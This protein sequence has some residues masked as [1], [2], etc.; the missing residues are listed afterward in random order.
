VANGAQKEI[1]CRYCGSP[2][3]GDE[4][5]GRNVF[6]ASLHGREWVRFHTVH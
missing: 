5:S 3:F 2:E 6:T 4:Q 1:D